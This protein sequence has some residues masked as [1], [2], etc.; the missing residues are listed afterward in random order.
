MV[1]VAGGPEVAEEIGKVDL[2]VAGEEGSVAAATEHEVGVEFAA[3]FGAAFGEDAGEVA[4]AGEFLAESR[5]FVAG[6]DAIAFP[7]VLDR[8]EV[9]AADGGDEECGGGGGFVFLAEVFDEIEKFARLAA[10]AFKEAEVAGL[11]EAGEFALS[12]LAGRALIDLDAAI[13]EG[14]EGFVPG[15]G[16]G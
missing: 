8:Q 4:H 1:V 2:A 16:V 15:H 7:A 11:I 14:E 6:E 9:V 12:K 5:D 13:E 10:D 3:E